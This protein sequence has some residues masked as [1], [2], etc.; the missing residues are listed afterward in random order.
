MQMLILFDFISLTSKTGLM[1]PNYAIIHLY[2]WMDTF[3]NIKGP[4]SGFW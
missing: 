4:V 3:V 1:L 2:T